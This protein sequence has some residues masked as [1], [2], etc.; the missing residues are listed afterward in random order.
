MS[1]EFL[2]VVHHFSFTTFVFIYLFCTMKSIYFLLISLS[3]GWSAFGQNTTKSGAKYQMLVDVNGAATKVSDIV[4]LN[5]SV[6]ADTTLIK[7][8]TTSKPIE[9]PIA[10]PDSVG[11]TEVSIM[12]ALLLMNIGDSLA[13]YQ[14][15]D[16]TMRTDPSLANAQNVVYHISLKKIVSKADMDKRR[17]AF[18]AAQKMFADAQPYFQ[19]RE[20]AVSDSIK[21]IAA[22]YLAGKLSPKTAPSGLKIMILH[23]GSGEVVQAGDMVFAGYF[24]VLT[25]GARFDDSYS[26]GQPYPFPVGGSQVIAGWDEGFQGLKEGTTAVL[27]VPGNL[28]YG[29][30]GNG[31]DIGPNAELI[32]FIEVLKKI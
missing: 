19:S 5:V 1:D 13:L 7:V 30:Q 16:S 23:E 15:V 14:R 3:F 32:F 2:F 20:K 28:G 22:D 4:S 10:S 21:T 18:G 25:S 17:E 9:L 6:Y 26:K 24:G 11:A 8:L 27:F 12:E 29:P 31:R